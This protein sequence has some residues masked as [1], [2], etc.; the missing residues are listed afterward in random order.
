M[1]DIE[2][3]ATHFEKKL[4]IAVV[5][6]G[7]T[8]CVA[9]SFVS[10]LRFSE[11]LAARG[12]KIIFIT[13]R[14]PVN[15]SD[16]FYKTIKA[17]RFPGVLLP[18]TEGQLRLAFTTSKKIERIL[19]EEKI[20]VVH[21]II[22]TP[23][24]LVTTKAAHH[25]GIE[26]VAH[27]HTQPENLFLH[28]PEGPWLKVLNSMFYRYMSWLYGKANTLI[29][30]SQFAKDRMAA[31]KTSARSCIISNGVNTA[32]FKLV[33]YE[34]LISTFNLPRDVV[35]ILYAGRLHPEKSL[36]TLISAMPLVLAHHP[37]VHLSLA[38]F[39]H[40]DTKLMQLTRDL[41]IESHVT[42]LGKVTN[43]EMVM[44]MSLCDIFVLPSLAELEGM[45]VLEAMSCGKPVVIADSP[46]SA[47]TYFVEENGYLF[48]HKDP[49]DLARHINTL[50]VDK[51]LR[52]AMGKKSFEISRRYDINE[53][54]KKLEDVYYSL[55]EM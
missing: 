38:G 30:P 42:F 45:V 19:S 49:T 18:K 11:L 24:A 50:V 29:Y 55:L 34:E 48:K 16:N 46:E 53:S 17:Y 27:S 6:D 47:S 43:D 26:I 54:V 40:M 23:L 31:I 14:S 13:S 10:T 5:C 4:N 8:D 36:E 9:G 35:H 1:N 21:N 41:G 25:L 7:V 22:P 52:D 15:P 37:K 3:N 20:D 51:E 39:G 28:M 32:H 33:P 2:L 12:H 44:A